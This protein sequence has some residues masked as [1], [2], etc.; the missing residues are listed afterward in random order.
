[1]VLGT[2]GPILD[3]AAGEAVLVTLATSTEW[4]RDWVS[5]G[6]LHRTPGW[7]VVRL[8]VPNGWALFGFPA[9][10]ICV[11]TGGLFLGHLRGVRYRPCWPG[12]AGGADR[13][14]Q[15]RPG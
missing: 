3:L 7:A 1:M 8:G 2:S 9:G 11:L 6:A 12:P 4:A 14:T 5:V 15:F 13:G 10:L